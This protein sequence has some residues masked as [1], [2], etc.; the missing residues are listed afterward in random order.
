MHDLISMAVCQ[1]VDLVYGTFFLT[2]FRD[3]P[4]PSVAPFTNIV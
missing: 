1:Q 3:A 4:I 2:Q